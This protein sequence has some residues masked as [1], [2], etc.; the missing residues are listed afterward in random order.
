MEQTTQKSY[1]IAEVFSKS[2]KRIYHFEGNIANIIKTP[3]IR[4]SDI[5]EIE[6]MQTAIMENRPELVELLTKVFKSETMAQHMA[7]KL[8]EDCND[9]SNFYL[10]FDF[11]NRNYFLFNDF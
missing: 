3:L 10:N 2:V 11:D 5:K 7:Y 9:M 8:N 4:T 6:K 1:T